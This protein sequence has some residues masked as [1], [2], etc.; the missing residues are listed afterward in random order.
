MYVCMYV[1]IYIYI[2]IY[3]YMTPVGATCVCSLEK[4]ECSHLPHKVVVSMRTHTYEC[5]SR[6]TAAAEVAILPA[7]SSLSYIGV[8]EHIYTYI[9]EYESTYLPAAAATAHL[10]C[11]FSAAIARALLC[12]RRQHTSAYVSIC[13]HTSEYVS[14]RLLPIFVVLSPPPLPGHCCVCVHVGVYV[15][16]CVYAYMS[17]RM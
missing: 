8:W 16:M 13:Q 15:C 9:Q 4:W 12:S 7:P 6:C 1:Y 14:I 10:R 2:Y 11:P 5:E 3:I 17:L